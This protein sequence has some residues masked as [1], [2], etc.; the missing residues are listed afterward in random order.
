MKNWLKQTIEKG[1]YNVKIL[2]TRVFSKSFGDLLKR[3]SERLSKGKKTLIVTPNPEFM[4]YAR[5]KAWFKLVLARSDFNIADGV[6]LVWAS[7]ILGEPIEERIAGVDLME[8]LC[9]EAAR[10]RWKVYLFGGA[11]GVA[12]AAFASLKRKYPDLQGWAESGPKLELEHWDK[13]GVKKWAD[14]IGRRG[15]DLLFVAMGMGKQEKFIFDNWKKLN[16]KLG[17]GVGGAFDYLSGQVARPPAWIRR[18]G[19]EW[20]YRLVKEP[21]RWRRQLALPKFIWLVLKERLG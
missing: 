4:V 20:L 1:R 3:V 19:F 15:A 14:K 10:R 21:G 9:R 2:G 12:K 5:E 17:M 11:P 18:L 13:R 6:G 8:A 16:V 7:R